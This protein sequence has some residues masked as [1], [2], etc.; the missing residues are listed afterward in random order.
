MN[1]V[2]EHLVFLPARPKNIM[3]TAL[4]EHERMRCSVQDR[5]AAMNT[6]E[7]EEIAGGSAVSERGR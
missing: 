2:L 7:L 3:G 4:T 5:A 1:F 6:G